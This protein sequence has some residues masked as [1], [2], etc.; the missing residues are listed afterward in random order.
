[1]VHVTLTASYTCQAPSSHL[2]QLLGLI[3]SILGGLP[4]S[5]TDEETEA[6]GD[7]NLGKVSH[8]EGQR[9]DLTRRA[10]RVR[11]WVMANVP[12]VSPPNGAALLE[13]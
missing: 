10:A 3:P 2:C 11:V 12:A 1:M 4:H 13:G 8:P 6:L 7:S 9:R 5:V